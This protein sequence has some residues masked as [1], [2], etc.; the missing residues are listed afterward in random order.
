MPYLALMVRQGGGGRLLGGTAA[1]VSDDGSVSDVLRL[2]NR[3]ER[4]TDEFADLDAVIGK[5]A[6]GTTVVSWMGHLWLHRL[7]PHGRAH[8]TQHVDL[9]ATFIARHRHHIGLASFACVKDATSAAAVAAIV[10]RIL[11]HGRLV[12]RTG[13][14]NV[15]KAFWTADFFTPL[16]Q[17]E[18]QSPP[19]W[20]HTPADVP[21]LLDSPK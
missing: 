4:P 7:G 2:E 19:G 14:D 8:Y 17:L 1:T 13:S 16:G 6:P 11:S 18:M 5:A 20:N 21:L 9:A 10:A 15:E 3:G 12:W